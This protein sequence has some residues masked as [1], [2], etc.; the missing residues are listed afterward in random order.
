MMTVDGGENKVG[1]SNWINLMD[2][3]LSFAE[4]GMNVQGSLIEFS[5]N[6]L[7][8][9]DEP[10]KCVTLRYKKDDPEETKFNYYSCRTCGIN[11]VCEW[12]TKGCHEG[13]DLLP[14]MM[15]HRPTWA[16]CYCV[17]KGCCKIANNKN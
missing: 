15:D 17:K 2:K 3:T 7:F 12:C 8:K 10:L 16:C 1:A 14:F 13:H 5:G 6:I 4:I 11:W 9:S